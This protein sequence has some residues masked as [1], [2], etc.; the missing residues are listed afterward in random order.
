[1]ASKKMITWLLD[2]DNPD[3]C[4]QRCLGSLRNVKK[5][6]DKSKKDVI[7]FSSLVY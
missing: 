7:I 6:L 3:G 1:M 4:H 2:W 5:M